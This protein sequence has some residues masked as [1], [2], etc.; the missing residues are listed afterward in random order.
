MHHPNRLHRAKWIK[1]GSGHVAESGMAQQTKLLCLACHLAHHRGNTR[2]YY[3]QGYAGKP[4]AAMSCLSGLEGAGRKR[5][6]AMMQCAALPPYA[7]R[8]LE[9]DPG[10]LVGLVSNVEKLALSDK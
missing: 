4:D 9:A 1:K 6:S 10:D 5:A 2:Q 8:Y 3:R 7:A